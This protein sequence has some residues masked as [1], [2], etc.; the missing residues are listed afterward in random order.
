[1][2]LVKT[3][4]DS[5]TIRSE[6]YDENYHSLSGALEE[7][8]KKYYEPCKIKPSMTILDIGFG[9]GYNAAMAIHKTKDIT[10]VSLE[11]DKKVLDMVQSIK[12]PDYF[13]E[14]YDII[15]QAARDLEYNKDDIHI[16]IILGD[17]TKTIKQ[18]DIKFDA[19][20]QDPFSP[21]K[22]PE[23][24]TEEFFKDVKRLMKPDAILATYSCARIVREN[25]KKAGFIVE[26]GPI[27][28]RRAPSTL[29]RTRE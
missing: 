26:D 21:P 18:L 2:E 19:V 24:W 29:A 15:K 8:E 5:F 27:I 14:T 25:L 12:V 23:L 22:N 13:K 16:R 7:S 4:D 6:E 28:G 9:L 1:M 17:A 11:K 3:D 20:F 10:I